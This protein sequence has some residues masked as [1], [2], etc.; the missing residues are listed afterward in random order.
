MSKPKNNYKD[1]R[2]RTEECQNRRIITK[3][4]EFQNRRIKTEEYLPLLVREQG[5]IYSSVCQNRRIII[6]TEE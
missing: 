5:N 4:E 6:K 3:T 1:R 2:M